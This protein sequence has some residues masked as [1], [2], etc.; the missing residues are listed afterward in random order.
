MVVKKLILILFC[1][2]QRFLLVSSFD[3]ELFF[4]RN[5]KLNGEHFRV[6]AHDVRKNLIFTIIK[7]YLVIIT[8]IKLR[9]ITA[10]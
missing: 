6:S 10:G 2:E 1:L 8:I 4:Q 7:I 3:N 5:T 9:K